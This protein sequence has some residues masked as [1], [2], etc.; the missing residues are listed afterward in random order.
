MNCIYRIE[1]NDKEIKEIYIGSTGKYSPPLDSKGNVKLLDET[2]IDDVLY[3]RFKRE[4][5]ALRNTYAPAVFHD[6]LLEVST[7]WLK[8]SPTP[9]KKIYQGLLGLKALSQYGKTILG[10]TAQIRNN[11][12]VPF[13]A[14]MNGNL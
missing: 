11:T 4:A 13:M 1:C 7:E 12:S 5:G 2:K 10:P 9:L 8:N 14:L 3:K 6:S